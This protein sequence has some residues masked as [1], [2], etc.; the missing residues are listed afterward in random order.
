MTA[1]AII[2]DNR[3]KN[4]L[5]IPETLELWVPGSHPLH[6]RSQI[7]RCQT[8]SKEI[9]TGDYIHGLDPQGAVIERKASFG[10]LYENLCTARGRH[11][12]MG[13]L[14]RF[15]AFR[16][17]ILL[18]EGDPQS[19]ESFLHRKCPGKPAIIRDLF[20]DAASA[21]GVWTLMMPTRTMDQRRAAGRWVAALLIQE[22]QR[23]AGHHRS[24][25]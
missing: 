14:E 19:L 22:Y 1:H 21:F 3:E 2:V 4:P 20:F 13:E 12:F 9:P 15:Q 7:V 11:R 25:P 17:P 24:D 8:V 5:P 18:L 16:R 10:E 6:A 23:H